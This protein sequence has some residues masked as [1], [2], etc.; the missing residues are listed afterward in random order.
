MILGFDFINFIL[1]F[2]L[3]NIFKQEQLQIN[4]V[5]AELISE[6]ETEIN[7]IVKSINDLNE[8]FKDLA[9]MIVDQ[10]NFTLSFTSSDQV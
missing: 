10:V 3:K 5:N 8:L 1:R 2:L 9:T 6:R 4:R 7:H